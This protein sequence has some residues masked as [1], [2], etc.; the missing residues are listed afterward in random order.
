MND[1]I[2]YIIKF[3][4]GEGND[5]LVEKVSYGD[6]EGASIIIK[7]SNFFD[8]HVYL[9]QKS[10]PQLPLQEIEKIPILFGT[11][12]IK[13]ENDRIIIEADLIASTFFLI[14]R[15]EECVNR[16]VRDAHGRFLGKKSL[17]YKA[18]FIDR[19]I[20]DEYGC[21]L[22]KYLRKAGIL[23]IEPKQE[24]RHIY[25]THDVDQIWTWDNYY[26]AF[27]SFAK[28][29]I[30]NENYKILPIKSA[31]NYK[32]YDPIYTFPE[33]ITW[34]NEVKDIYGAEKCTDLYFMM[35]CEKKQYVD[36]GYCAN[37]DRTRNLIEY[38]KD[39]G[40]N[41]GI[42]TSYSA[43]LNMNLLKTEIDNIKALS[44]IDIKKARNHYLASREPED[45]SYYIENGI[46]DDFTMAY[47]DVAGF[48]LGTSRPVKWINPITMKLTNLTLHPM[49]VMEC[50][51]DSSN[52]MNID[53]IEEAFETVKSLID[54]VKLHNGEVVLLWHSPSIYPN[55]NSYQR[56]LYKMV[57]NYIMEQ[58]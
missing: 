40:A 8:M 35:G 55:K 31:H 24:F 33:L 41:I 16:N 6:K 17:P 9:T 21:L 57:L 1:I 49:T 22:R 29:V 30:N 46:T 44:P 36:N 15:Y 23:A 20:V 38:L 4:L 56:Q 3:L 34:D 45:Y 12:N 11:P 43:S 39:S 54:N 53:N 19:A 28:K 14:T 26:K 10:L 58:K 32:K 5:S 48:R 50:T 51:L 37:K 27:R 7:R 25:L 52:Y 13:E 2:C 18:E 42:H 47:A